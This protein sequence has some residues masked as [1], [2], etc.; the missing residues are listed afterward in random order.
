MKIETH[1]VIKRTLGLNACNIF[2]QHR[3]SKRKDFL[4]EGRGNAFGAGDEDF[5]FEHCRRD[6][7][8]REGS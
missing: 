1:T 6:R 7:R 5:G 3:I 8:S 4:F 2:G